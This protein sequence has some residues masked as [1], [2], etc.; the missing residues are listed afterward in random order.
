MRAIVLAFAALVLAVPSQTLGAGL[1]RKI[2]ADPNKRYR[3][4]QRHGPWMIMVA[5]MRDVTEEERRIDGMSAQE[6]ADRMVLGLRKAGVPAYTFRRQQS[7]GQVETT[8][9]QSGERVKRAFVANQDRVVVVAGNYE[10]PD[11]PVAKKTL[12]W[13]K[14]TE[15]KRDQNKA[16]EWRKQLFGFLADAANGA[17]YPRSGPLRNAFL[18]PNPLIDATSLR[19]RRDP[20]LLHLNKDMEH[21]LALCPGKYSLVIAT[22][23]G[24]SNTHMNDNKLGKSADKVDSKLGSTLDQAYLDA[25]RLCQA[26]R[27]GKSI[28]Y[29]RNFETYVYHDRHYSVVTIGAFDDPKDPRIRMLS[30]QFGSKSRVDPRNGREVET[31]ELFSVPRRPK[32]RQLPRFMW[33]LDPKPELIEVPKL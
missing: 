17:I 8:S 29:D 1:G 7:L 11:D 4:T 10:S 9:R 14:G 6:A 13:I 26:M 2:D 25:W 28:G 18:I 23:R 15:E 12:A 33:M 21:S 32:P 30:R 27:T 3:L 19:S 22:F 31:A 24:K 20:L 16:T 5:S